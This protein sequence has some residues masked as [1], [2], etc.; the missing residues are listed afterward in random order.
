MT[1]FDDLLAIIR[2]LLPTAAIT[3][4][5]AHDVKTKSHFASVV[6]GHAMIIVIWHEGKTFRV[7]TEVEDG[8]GGSDEVEFKDSELHSA[9]SYFV[10][11][12]IEKNLV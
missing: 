5:T 3:T 10:H 12:V 1:K 9:V 4:D 11:H 8:Y 2:L 6:V 7:I